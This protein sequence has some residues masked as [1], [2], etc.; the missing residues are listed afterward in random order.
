MLEGVSLDVPPG[1][2]LSV[3]GPNGAGKSTLLRALAGLLVAR[4]TIEVGGRPL[5]T[6]TPRDRARVVALVPQNPVMPEGMPVLDY[7]ML[8]RHPH[9]PFFGFETA[10]DVAVVERILDRLDLTRFATRPITTLSGGERQRAVIARA[11]AQEAPVL[12][13]D[14]PTTALDIGHQQ[15]VMGLVDRLR[16]SHGLTVVSALHDLTLAGAH[17]DAMVMLCGGRVVATG[18]PHEVLRED[19]I[20]R[21]YRAAVWVFDHG[22]RPVVVPL[23]G[24]PYGPALPH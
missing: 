16:H 5:S 12:L 14:E 6:L 19:V 18:T 22:R 23:P 10:D 24:A 2:W 7:V 15:E 11:L 1:E 21:Y 13:L 4:G 8:G 17:A 20:E 9:I 3:V